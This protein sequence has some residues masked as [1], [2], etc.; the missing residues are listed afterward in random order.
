MDVRVYG[1]SRQVFDEI[2]ETLRYGLSRLDGLP[3]R[4]IVLG[5]HHLPPDLRPNDIIY[6]LE[7]RESPLLDNN[8]LHL[9]RQHEVWDYSSSNVRWLRDNGVRARHVPIGFVPELQRI[10]KVTP[11]IDVLFYG[12]VNERRRRILDELRRKGLVVQEL[13]NCYGNDRDALIGRSKIVLNTHFY[14]TKI[15]EMVRCSYLFANKICV[16]S[17]DSVDVPERMRTEIPFAPY[18]HLVDMCTSTIYLGYESAYGN[19]C[20]AC[21]KMYDETAILREAIWTEF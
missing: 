14:E 5:A 3:D 19:R 4:T 2:A 17:E 1:P 18:E 10:N 6:N 9:Y 21:F 16:V 12:L 7:Q 13:V 20:H 8:A 11:D 15:F